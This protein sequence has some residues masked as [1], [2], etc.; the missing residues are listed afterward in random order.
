[1][2]I[3]NIEDL[4][5]SEITEEFLHEQAEDMG[6]ELG[7]DT[8]QGSI[9]MDAA[10]GHI[11][12]T[13]KFFNDL[14]SVSEI[15]SILTMTGDI[16]DE[17]LR[18]KGMSR[19]PPVDT[20]AT[21]YVEFVGAEPEIGDSVTCGEHF[22]TVDKLDDKWVI[23][24]EEL[25]TDM[26]N[27][28]P[29][30]PVIP[31][32]D[33][34]NLI[35]ATLKE[36]AIPAVD[37]EGDDS[38]R[39][40]FLDMISGPSEN[41]N[42]AQLQSWCENIEG[43]GRAKIIPL[44]KGEGTTLGIIISSEGAKPTDKVVELVQEIIDPGAA[45]MGEGMATIGLHFTVAAAQ[46]TKIN[47]TVDVAKKAESSLQNVQDAVESAIKGY[48]KELALHSYTDITVVRYNS[49]G[50]LLSNISDIIDYDNLLLNG[51]TANITCDAYHVPVMG[52]VEANGNL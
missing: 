5:L 1:M 32:R 17:R 8:S 27:L 40:R 50:A 26:N 35:S 47:V 37:M 31:E 24:S 18:E 19:N 39:E 52:E 30:L 45:G 44:W 11:I 21:Y 28:V 14:N 49:I 23:I 25:G 4:E 20:P 48:L 51:G 13:S 36:V 12:R 43:V 41:C 3:K 15:I 38:A 22:F 2:A 10:E 9:Y 34:D 33:V 29:G 46:E 16:L 42:R 6:D 7:V